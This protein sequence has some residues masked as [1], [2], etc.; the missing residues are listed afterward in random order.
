M[1]TPKELMIS[2][3]KA[4]VNKDWDYLVETSLHQTLQ[5]FEK[6]SDIEWVK[7]DV[8]H[9]YKNIVE[10]KAY[11]KIDSLFEVLHEK[12]S[13]V[14]VDD[15]W[16]YQDGDIIDSHISKNEPCPCGSQKKFKKCC[17]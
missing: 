9:A 14:K 1:K 4:F 17:Y 7:L 2:R 3:Y 16:K 8:L 11:Y 5:D 6:P 12:S 10:F 15:T 13:F